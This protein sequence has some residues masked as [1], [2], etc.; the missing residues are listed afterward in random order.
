MSDKNSKDDQSSGASNDQHPD[1]ISA[2]MLDSC[3]ML[4]EDVLSF[5]E[6]II[7]GM[8]DR[9]HN[10]FIVSFLEFMQGLSDLIISSIKI[11]GVAAYLVSLSFVFVLG[12]VFSVMRL[13]PKAVAGYLSGFLGSCVDSY[14]HIAEAN[15]GTPKYPI[16]T[17]LLTIIGMIVSGYGYFRPV[18]LGC[19]ALVCVWPILR[20]TYYLIVKRKLIQ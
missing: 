9:Y 6:P 13:S 15:A 12:L 3:S 7:S 20:V 14:H 19:L 10:I 11:L 18:L 17:I 16:V 1:M 8:R 4:F 5:Q 2:G